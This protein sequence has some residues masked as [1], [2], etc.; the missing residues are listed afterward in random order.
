M[1]N[2]LRPE[3]LSEM[4]G[5]DDN[6][7][8]IG[9]SIQAAKERNKPLGHLLIDG[10][11]GLGKTTLAMCVAN[12]IGTDLRIANAATIK[13]P[14]DLVQILTSLRR[15]DVVFIDEIHGLPRQVEE[16]LY[17]AMEDFFICIP[18]GRTRNIVKIEIEPFT[19]IGATTHAGQVSAPMISRFRY[20]EQLTPYSDD[21]IAK[22]VSMNAKKI[23]KN[24][25]DDAAKA[26]AIRS[27]NTPRLSVNNLE[28]CM[29]LAQVRKYDDITLDIVED[30]MNDKGI[31]H[32]GFNTEDRRYLYEM[33]KTFSGGPAG[34]NALSNQLIIEPST[35][36]NDIEPYLMVRRM[37]LRTPGGRC[38]AT[39]G[40]KYA[41]QHFKLNE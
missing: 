37:I 5:M 39:D 41:Q 34:L 21:D 6:R 33:Y 32:Y 17:Q 15:K 22:I 36:E 10:S 27:R 9:I 24:I 4:I 38:L 1:E 20:R 35:L 3:R 12:E 40:W 30:A 7:R 8:R 25:H 13:M 11:R 29:D 26:I 2:I 18:M 14:K 31:D 23:G 19:L 16:F 28:W